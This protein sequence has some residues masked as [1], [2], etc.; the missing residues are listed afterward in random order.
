MTPPGP[1]TDRDLA[2]NPSSVLFLEGP[3]PLPGDQEAHPG[4]PFP[5]M[6]FTYIADNRMQPLGPLL[7][8]QL[9]RGDTGHSEQGTGFSAS[10]SCPFGV[11]FSFFFCATWENLKGST[12]DCE[13]EGLCEAPGQ[14][15]FHLSEFSSRLLLSHLKPLNRINSHSF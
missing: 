7:G 8:V 4:P 2:V 6:I 9:G 14:T 15:F 13:P 12:H 5:G 3:R 1:G 11:S 10:P